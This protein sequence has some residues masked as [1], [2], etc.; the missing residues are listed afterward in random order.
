MILMMAAAVV[1]ATHPLSVWRQVCVSRE[2]KKKT[3]KGNK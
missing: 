1:V 2:G 3:N